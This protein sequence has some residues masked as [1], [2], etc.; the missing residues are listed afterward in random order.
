MDRVGDGTPYLTGSAV[1]R[2]PYLARRPPAQLNAYRAVRSSDRRGSG[3]GERTFDI[4][5]YVD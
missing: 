2:M 4:L 3:T 5:A 1:G